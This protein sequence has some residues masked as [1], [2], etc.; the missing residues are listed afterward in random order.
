MDTGTKERPCHPIG[1]YLV[2]ENRLLREALVR[3]FQKEANI[4]VV[5][6]DQAR[7]TT[8][9]QVAAASSDVLLLDS[10]NASTN[11]SILADLAGNQS[12][13]KIILFGM[14]EDPE[15]FIKAVRMGVGAY[16]YKDAS[17][18]EIISAVR[19]VVRGEAICPPRLCM[20]LFRQVSQEFRQRSGLTDDAACLKLGLTFR[21]RQLV[22]LV[23]KGMSN[24]EIASNL[25]L[26]ECTVKNHIYRIMKQVEA[27]SRQEA[28]DL[29]RAGGYLAQA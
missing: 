18:A 27:G 28:V 7:E 12:H 21:Q 8:A 25:N 11:L 5:G 6:Q 22:S 9:K 10:L 23:A 16:L 3:L 14:E 19:G 2:V 13:I 29:I 26:S 4:S 15:C 20:A 24:K 1:V 17:S